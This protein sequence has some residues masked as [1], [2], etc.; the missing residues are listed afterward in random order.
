MGGV[1]AAEGLYWELKILVAKAEAPKSCSC[2]DLVAVHRLIFWRAQ[3]LLKAGEVPR[4]GSFKSGFAK[5]FVVMKMPLSGVRCSLSLSCSR[6]VAGGSCRAL[7]LTKFSGVAW[8]KTLIFMAL[9]F[10]LA[11]KLSGGQAT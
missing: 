4:P 9:S 11:L 10:W 3:V 5:E 1:R 2:K 8:H 6:L 7:K